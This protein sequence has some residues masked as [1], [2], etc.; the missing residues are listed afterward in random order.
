MELHQR[1]ELA[2]WAFRP[3]LENALEA[4]EPANQASIPGGNT[5]LHGEK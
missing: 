4:L 5:A 1:R 2:Q 3:F